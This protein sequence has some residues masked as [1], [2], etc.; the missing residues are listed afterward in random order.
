MCDLQ[1]ILRRAVEVLLEKKMIDEEGAHNYYMSGITC[2]ELFMHDSIEYEECELYLQPICS[3]DYR[4]LM[5]I[6][7]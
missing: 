4:I 6:I 5:I 7:R 2:F 3:L 1:K